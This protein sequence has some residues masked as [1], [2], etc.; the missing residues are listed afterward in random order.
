MVARGFGYLLFFQETLTE[1]SYEGLRI[2][3]MQIDPPLATE[4]VVLSCDPTVR[5]TH[6]VNAMKALI[7]TMFAT[8]PTPRQV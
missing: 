4:P 1:L 7:T 8:S 2:V 3:D 5:P 6:R